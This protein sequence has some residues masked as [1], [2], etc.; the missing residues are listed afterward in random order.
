ML[1]TR[2]FRLQIFDSPLDAVERFV[3][4]LNVGINEIPMSQETLTVLR[5]RV[6][7]WFDSGKNVT[8][9]FAARPRLK[10]VGFRTFV[11]DANSS[12]VEVI[13]TP[14]TKSSDPETIAAGLFLNFLMNPHHASL[15][16]RC[17][18]CGRY[19]INGTRRK[20]VRYCTKECGKQFTS[21][22]ANQKSR[23]KKYAENLEQVRKAIKE[24]SLRESKIPWKDAVA[25]KTSI[26]KRWITLAVQKKVISEPVHSSA[27]SRGGRTGKRKL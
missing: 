15:R 23:E 25:A 17:A 13:H 7:D 18:K 3:R 21:R 24:L 26:S 5:Q 16:D 10:K 8:K 19:F 9:L 6:Q 14:D 1:N 4:T 20:F 2:R 22:L 27:R 11:R 12:E